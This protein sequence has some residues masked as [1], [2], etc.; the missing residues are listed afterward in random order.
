[1]NTINSWFPPEKSFPL[2]LGP[3]QVGTILGISARAA[4]RYLLLLRRVHQLP[5][6]RTIHVLLFSQ[7]ASVSLRSIYR[8][9]HAV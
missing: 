9:L 4:R 8:R 7:L 5:S 2:E 6:G 3:Q 1:M